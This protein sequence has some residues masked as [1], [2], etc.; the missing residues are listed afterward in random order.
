M[1]SITGDG[2]SSLD[3]QEG[4]GDQS[5]GTELQSVPVPAYLSLSFI[6]KRVPKTR[7]P[8]DGCGYHRKAKLLVT[9][10]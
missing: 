2:I 5:P 8:V 4:D 9:V 3:S 7:L 6:N 1:V 10:T